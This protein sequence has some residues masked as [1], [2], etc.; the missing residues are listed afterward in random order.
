MCSGIINQSAIDGQKTYHADLDR[1][2]R[3]YIQRH[4]SEFVP[5]GVEAIAVAPIEPQTP[6]IEKDRRTSMDGGASAEAMRKTREHERNQRSLQWA[7][8]TFSGAYG[9]AKRSTTGA[10]ELIKD[11]WDQSTSTTI[12]IF[13][14][15]ILVLSNIYTLTMVT[16]RGNKVLR[17]EQMKLEEREAWVQGIVTGLWEEL[18]A[19]NT[20]PVVPLPPSDNWQQELANLNKTL[21]SVEERLRLIRKSL[22][23]LN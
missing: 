10:L 15:V 16:S 21:D 9:V 3:Q 13:M 4:Q 23:T 19:G 7:Y 5:E 11:A 2:M 17:K 8:D 6:G 12:L 1:A 14:I 18:A 20:R 22:N